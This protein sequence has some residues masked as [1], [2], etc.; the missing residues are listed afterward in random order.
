MATDWMA[1]GIDVAGGA[2]LGAGDQLIQN[3]DEKR[4]RTAGTLSH[5]KEYGTYYNYGV[6]LLGIVATAMGWVK[7]DWVTRVIM[8]GAQLAGR[9]V[10]YTL[11]KAA[12]SAPWRPAPGGGTGARSPVQQTQKPGFEKAGIT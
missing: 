8:G 1:V 6:P 2:V 12:Q 10:T 7:G 9:K 11:T 5:W 3:E 4:R